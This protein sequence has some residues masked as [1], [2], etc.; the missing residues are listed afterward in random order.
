MGKPAEWQREWTVSEEDES[1]IWFGADPRTASESNGDFRTYLLHEQGHWLVAQEQEP[2]I[3]VEG[4]GLYGIV[5]GADS[6]VRIVGA[7]GGV[8]YSSCIAGDWELAVANAAGVVIE[9]LAQNEAVVF[10]DPLGLLDADVTFDNDRANI[11]KHLHCIG[12]T[13]E[14]P[15]L[16]PALRQAMKTAAEIIRPRLF[17]YLRT[18]AAYRAHRRRAAVIEA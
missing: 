12:V 8:Q 15:K 2:S 18:G 13:A 14:S 16:L 7:G 3:R 17:K 5:H 1:Q 11:L 4:L 9:K 10:D 6:G